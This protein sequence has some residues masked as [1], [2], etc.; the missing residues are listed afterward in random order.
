[1]K[2]FVILIAVVAVMTM[3]SMG[4]SASDPLDAHELELLEWGISRQYMLDSFEQQMGTRKRHPMDV[5]IDRYKD[6]VKKLLAKKLAATTDISY[7]ESL[8]IAEQLRKPID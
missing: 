3:C 1:M 6:Q 8:K 5:K 2:K 4:I 7:K